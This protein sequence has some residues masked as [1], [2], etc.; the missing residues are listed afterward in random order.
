MKNH[1]EQYEN[2]KCTFKPITKDFSTVEK[3]FNNTRRRENTIEDE[4]NGKYLETPR[5]HTTSTKALGVHRTLELY[6]LSRP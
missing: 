1:K 4:L 2:S 6:S 3:H 5:G